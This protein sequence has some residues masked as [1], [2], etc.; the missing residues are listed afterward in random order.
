V[1]RPKIGIIIGSTRA[2]RFGEK[3]ARWIYGIASR[4]I[5]LDFEIVD[6]RDYP[7]PFFEG[8]SPMHVPVTNEV[9]QRWGA[10]MAELD[11]YL[12]VTPE[13]N[14][15]ITGVLKN[16]LDWAYL[17]YNR[18]PAAYLGYG[19]VGG[20]RAIEQLRLICVELQ[21]A[22]TR[23]GVHI[24]GPNA[25]ALIFQGKSFDEL[26]LPQLRKAAET[27]LNELA[28]WTK[29]LKAAREASSV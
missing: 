11:G 29:A 21:M 1:S 2:Q 6:L 25:Y 16:A 20:A 13:Y 27:M 8:G 10:K 3:A 14:R 19:G 15:S 26:E 18:K 23:T 4:R 7:L 9:A 24:D 28:W 5:D 22:P 17:E 12:F